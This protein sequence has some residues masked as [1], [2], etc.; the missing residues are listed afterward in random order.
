MSSYITSYSIRYNLGIIHQQTEVA[1]MHA[2]GDIINEDPATPDHDK[3]LAWA[4]WAIAN[5]GLAHQTFL[6]PVAG[7]QSI[8]DKVEAAPDGSTV[9]DGDIQFVVNSALPKV[10]AGWISPTPIPP[11]P[12][13]SFTAK[14]KGK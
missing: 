7:N 2:A 6:W 5:S 13:P 4:Q 12:S 9:L 1:V 14:K 10:V 3:R 11:G 8:I